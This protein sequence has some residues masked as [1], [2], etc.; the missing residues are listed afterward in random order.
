MSQEAAFDHLLNPTYLSFTKLTVRRVSTLLSFS[1][2]REHEGTDCHLEKMPV[3][4]FWEL[5]PLSAGAIHRMTAPA[6]AKTGISWL[7]SKD[8][9]LVLPSVISNH[10]RN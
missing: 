6:R 2:S 7:A 1:S 4:H 3:Q 9:K 5:Y 8:C 10:G